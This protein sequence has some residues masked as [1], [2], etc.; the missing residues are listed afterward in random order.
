V[1]A[2]GALL[3]TAAPDKVDALLELWAAADWKATVVGRILPAAGDYR[4]TRGGAPVPFP[5][6]TADE[7][8]KLWQ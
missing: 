3:A 2:S 4:A 6:F 7:I 8:T 5:E 1:I